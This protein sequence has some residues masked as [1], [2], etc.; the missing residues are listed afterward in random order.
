MHRP[1]FG[2]TTCSAAMNSGCIL[3][4]VLV[5]LVLVAPHP[6]PAEATSVCGS[7]GGGGGAEMNSAYRANLDLVVNTFPANASSSPSLYGTAVVG[8]GP[9]QTVYAI[10]LCRG[11][12]VPSSCLVCLSSGLADARQACPS[13]V[14]VTIDY[15]D[16]CHMR[17]SDVD[18]LASTN[19]SEL[20]PFFSMF[21]SVASSVADRFN[22]L[23]TRLLNATADYAAAASSSERRF[24]A[25]GEMEVD[26]DYSDGQ[27]SNIFATAQCTPDLTPGQCHACLA[28]VMAEVPS[29]VF[30]RNSTG[31]SFVGDR[32]G[33]RFA[34][35]SFYNV[36]AMVHLQMRPQGQG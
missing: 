7:S 11:D 2:F 35:Y 15:S 31:A 4:T 23:V 17:F 16:S 21:P 25:T 20:R 27:F 33:L 5:V 34:T 29:Q 13:S 28:G 19:N 26:R 36:D 9:N 6:P 3:G 1:S 8:D 12:L 24:F 18:F 32:C 22:G 14:D 10:A 30:P